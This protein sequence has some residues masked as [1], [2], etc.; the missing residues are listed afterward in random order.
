MRTFRFPFSMACA[1]AAALWLA[2]AR[3]HGADAMETHTPLLVPAAQVPYAAQA[4]MLAST[5]AGSRIVAVG[6]HGVVLLSDDGGKTHRQAKSVPADVSL[7]SVAFVDASRGW[8]VGH[9][10][11]ILHTADGGDTWTL[12]RSDVQTDRPLF[13]VHFLDAAHGVAVGLWSLVLMA[14]DGGEHWRPVDMAPPAGARKADLNLQ[15]L[16]ADA[17]GRLF[18]VAEKGM[19]LRSDDRGLH[20]HYLPSGYKGSF[21]SGIATRDGTLIVAGLRGSLYRSADDGRT[22]QRLDTRSKSSITALALA[23]KRIIGVG[24]EGLVLRSD[25][26][27]MTF[28]SDV[29]PDRLALTAVAVDAEGH[30]VMYSRQ[31]IFRT[32]G[33]DATGN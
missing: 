29:R 21:W 25:D 2:A 17:R 13:A 23:G 4:T 16:F 32:D 6:D 22:W 18:A 9:W 19:I 5:R 20:W 12:Q 14:D 30:A 10:G 15:G 31:G 1:L 7:T 27:G 26:E 24:L 3:A 33:I 8:A 28:T 11:V